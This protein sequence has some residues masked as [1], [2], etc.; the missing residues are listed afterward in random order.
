VFLS[1][2]TQGNRRGG[3]YREKGGTGGRKSSARGK[4]GEKAKETNKNGR[5][6]RSPKK[7]QTK[8]GK[9]R[10]GGQGVGHKERER[11]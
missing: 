2:G 1:I 9:G 5:P 7:L 6:I 11:K 8:N 10:K 4:R 3:N